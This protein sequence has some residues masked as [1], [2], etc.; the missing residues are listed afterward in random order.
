MEDTDTWNHKH[1]A[2]E[3]QSPTPDLTCSSRHHEGI[4][5]YLQVRL[6]FTVHGKAETQEV[7]DTDT[8][9]HKHKA[10]DKDQLGTID[11][12]RMPWH[13][14]PPQDL[15]MRTSHQAKLGERTTNPPI[16]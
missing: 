12:K 4:I 2:N 13:L 3:V 8:W 10:D 1:K 15:D 6:N 11:S 14:Y 9:N 5:R 7:E 16:P